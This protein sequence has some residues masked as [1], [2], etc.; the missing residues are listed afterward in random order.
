MTCRVLL[1]TL[2]PREGCLYYEG[3]LF[4]G[5]AYDVQ[6]HRVVCNTKIV[7]GVP[8]GPAEAWDVSRSRVLYSALN[9]VSIDNV[10]DQFPREG[11]YL[12][13][14][15][16][17]G[18]AYAF[19][20]KSGILLREDDL[21][22]DGV[23]VSR[24][25][26]PSGQIK[27]E[28]NRF[29]P[30]GVRESE[31]WHENGQRAGIQ[32]EGWGA[33]YTSSGTLRTLRLESSYPTSALCRLNFGVDEVLDLAGPGIADDIVVRLDGLPRVKDLELRRTTLSPRGLDT[34]L[35]CSHLKEFCVRRNSGFD[36]RD[37]KQFLTHFPDCSWDGRMD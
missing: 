31:T 35:A 15:F 20:T 36:E 18:I 24:E 28:F 13:S 10:S 19:D 11:A 25:W 29:G 37:V 32:S 5:I 33:G 8:H 1:T 23:G 14:S 34:F 6:K 16:F 9:L 3:K 4:S 2:E 22:S 7:E 27:S 17:D 30:D 21:H 12:N 26:Y